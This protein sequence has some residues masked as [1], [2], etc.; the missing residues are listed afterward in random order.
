MLH[1]DPREGAVQQLRQERRGA[2]QLRAVAQAPPRQQ[3]AV[4]RDVRVRSEVLRK[5]TTGV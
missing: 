2:N 4:V 1:G 5:E 3:E